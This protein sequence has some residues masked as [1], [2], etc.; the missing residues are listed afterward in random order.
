MPAFILIL[1]W[2]TQVAMAAPSVAVSYFDNTAADAAVAPLQK[3][4]ADML[5]TDLSAS[6]AITVVERSRLQDILQ[7]IELQKN[8]CLK[9]SIDWKQ[10]V[11]TSAFKGT[12]S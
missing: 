8:P 10:W 9:D 11:D 4:L 2:M 1:V 6:D 7:E 12:Q 5:I 3:G